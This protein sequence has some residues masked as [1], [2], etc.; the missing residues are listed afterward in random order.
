MVGTPRTY[1]NI[2]KLTSTDCGCF[3]VWSCYCNNNFCTVFFFL[4]GTQ[5]CF[6]VLKGVCAYLYAQGVGC[7]LKEREREKKNA[8]NE[9]NYSVGETLKGRFGES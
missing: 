1:L 6:E 4:K 8:K 7:M 5:P 2:F 3:A 9:E